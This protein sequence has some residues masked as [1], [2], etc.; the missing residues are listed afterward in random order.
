MDVNTE[1]IIDTPNKIGELRIKL[2]KM[3]NGYYKNPEATAAV[4]D[5]DGYY[6]TGDIVYY[7]EDYYVYY[8]DR[9]KDMMKYR[10][11]YVRNSF[12]YI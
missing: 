11:F 4:F 5:S 6:C 3:F 12:I 9:I 7:D 2:D 10:S 8:V 1:K